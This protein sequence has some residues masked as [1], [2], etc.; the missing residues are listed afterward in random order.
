MRLFSRNMAAAMVGAVAFVALSTA[1]H[2][3]TVT[4]IFSTGVND[5]GETLGL[6][7]TDTH[8]SGGSTTVYSNPAFLP[9]D[10]AGTAGGSAFLGADNVGAV[11]NYVV[12]F[13][14]ASVHDAVLAG[15]WATDNVGLDILVNGHSTGISLIDHTVDAFNQLHTFS[16]NLGIS[17][18]QL[19]DNTLTFVI[20]ND[21]PGLIGA[22]RAANLT[23]TTTPIPPSI[24]MFLTALGGLG[25]TAY[26]RRRGSAAA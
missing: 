18:F 20:G 14:L 8:Y 7:D 6:G 21:D 12:H 16:Q 25:F 11:T 1:S 3:G 26:R 2:A 24:L 4:T 9:N 22:F 17:F 13:T 15:A 19:G 23:V 5:S 10:P